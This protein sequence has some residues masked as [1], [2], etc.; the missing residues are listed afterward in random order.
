MQS[1]CS[2]HCTVSLFLSLSPH[3]RPK[4]VFFASVAFCSYNEPGLIRWS[5]N[6]TGAWVSYWTEQHE[7]HITVSTLS[8]LPFL[9]RSAALGGGRGS[10]LRSKSKNQFLGHI[11][12]V[13]LPCSAFGA[14]ANGPLNLLGNWFV[15]YSFPFVTFFKINLHRPA[16]LKTF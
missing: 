15:N 11:P 13:S 4:C 7:K 2:A 8:S 1:V 3:P 14:E 16:S 9:A 6:Q 5:W 12:K 10:D